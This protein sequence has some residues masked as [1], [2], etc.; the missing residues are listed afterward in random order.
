MTT[1]IAHSNI[2]LAKYWGKRPG[3]G[4]YPAVPSLSMTLGGMT[5]RTRVVLR[6]DL[7]AHALVLNSVLES[8]EPLERVSRFL[9]DLRRESGA[10]SF[11]WVESDNDFPT[12]SGLASSASGFAALALAA[13][14]AYGLDTDPKTVSHRARRGSASAAR[15][16]FGGFVELAAGPLAPTG[17]EFL[18]AVQVAPEDHADL[19]LLVCVVSEEKKK[20]GSTSGMGTTAAISPYYA[21]WLEEAPRLFRKARSAL[22]AHDFTTLG[23][24]TEASALA[25]HASAMAAGVFYFKPITLTLFERVRELRSDGLPAYATADAGPHVKVLVP[26]ASA[27]Q[28][29]AALREVPG[30]LHV[31]CM[32][33]G[34]GARLIVDDEA[35]EPG[36]IVPGNHA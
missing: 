35:H 27:A 33:P 3:L 21:A 14:A 4:N 1:A 7:H 29:G 13:S 34:P 30:V 25:M 32:Q 31:R 24:I 36:P 20:I 11:A 12:A 5:T 23:T 10:T 19:S 9:E 8:G 15:S 17:E 26:S 22:L 16:L 6:E 18:G 2:A 28:V